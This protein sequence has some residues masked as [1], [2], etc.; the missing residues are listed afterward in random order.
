MP[1]D[2]YASWMVPHT[3]SISSCCEQGAIFT[4]DTYCTY[5]ISLFCMSGHTL[6]PNERLPGQ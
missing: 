2:C 6:D 5:L 4:V 3:T 1:K